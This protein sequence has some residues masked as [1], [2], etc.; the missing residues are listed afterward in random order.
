MKRIKIGNLELGGV[1]KAVGVID[2]PIAA[3]RLK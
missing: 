3:G 2:R 1:P